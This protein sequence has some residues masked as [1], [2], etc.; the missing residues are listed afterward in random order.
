MAILGPWNP[1]DDGGDISNICRS[2][3]W[4]PSQRA[5]ALGTP[6]EPI[7]GHYPTLK[8]CQGMGFNC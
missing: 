6:P 1:D 5:L 3:T 4:L 7:L 8:P 2:L